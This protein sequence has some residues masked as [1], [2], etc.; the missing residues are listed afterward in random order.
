[1]HLSILQILVYEAPD[2][3]TLPLPEKMDVVREVSKNENRDERGAVPGR[4]DG[5]GS[6]EGHRRQSTLS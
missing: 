4:D 5:G 2:P 6:R 1:M 3:V